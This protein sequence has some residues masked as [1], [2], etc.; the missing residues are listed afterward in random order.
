MQSK[1]ALQLELSVGCATGKTQ[2]CLQTQ[3]HCWL[4]FSSTDVYI[5]ELPAKF[6]CFVNISVCVVRWSAGTCSLSFLMLR[7]CW[8]SK[9][10]IRLTP[11][12]PPLRAQHRQYQSTRAI[13]C[14]CDVRAAS[15]AQSLQSL[16]P[17][18]AQLQR[19]PF[20]TDSS[21]EPIAAPPAR[22]SLINHLLRLCT[23]RQPLP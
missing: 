5:F 19:S 13:R 2:C 16:L 7:R 18:D 1:P 6:P 11:V 9:T 10:G 8:C 14:V 22:Y 21:P 23:R 20:R 3:S 17:A 12:R 4:E 15:F